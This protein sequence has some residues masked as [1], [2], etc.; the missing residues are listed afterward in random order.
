MCVVT[1]L[2]TSHRREKLYSV[3]V[4][5]DSVNYACFAAAFSRKIKIGAVLFVL[6]MS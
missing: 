5:G 6:F 3:N 2:Y 4:S 1:H